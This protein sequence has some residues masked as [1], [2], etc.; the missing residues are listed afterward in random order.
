VRISDPKDRFDTWA[1][2]AT[3]Y[4]RVLETSPGSLV[5]CSYCGKEYSQEFLTLQAAKCPRCAKQ[6]MVMNWPLGEDLLAHLRKTDPER[7]G[8]ARMWKDLEQSEASLE[9]SQARDKANLSESIWKEEFTR[10]FDIQS[11][12]YE[13][14]ARFWQG[15]PESKRFG[16]KAA[17]GNP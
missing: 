12:G 1:R 10:V 2:C 17:E 3:G 8:L 16:G 5:E 4:Y 6:E 13:G 11:R 15:A 9:Q 14:P 7:D